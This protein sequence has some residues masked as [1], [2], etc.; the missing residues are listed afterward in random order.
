MTHAQVRMPGFVG[1]TPSSSQLER[2]Q[3]VAR[4]R[5]VRRTKETSPAIA[6][7]VS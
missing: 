3:R 5:G 2:D 1:L 4:G 6:F 7:A